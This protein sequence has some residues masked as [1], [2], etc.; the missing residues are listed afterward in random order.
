MTPAIRPVGA[1]QRPSDPK[2]AFVCPAI[3][4]VGRSQPLS[5]LPL[6]LRLFPLL[7]DREML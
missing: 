3:R 6:S 4:L 5:C 1:E 7:G 2:A